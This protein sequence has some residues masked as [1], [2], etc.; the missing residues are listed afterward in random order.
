MSILDHDD[1]TLLISRRLR[2]LLEAD[3]HTFLD[4]A[5]YAI[6]AWRR[7]DHIIVDYLK[8]HSTSVARCDIFYSSSDAGRNREGSE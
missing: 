8:K 2:K 5:M 7:T 6:P 3:R 1:A 4:E